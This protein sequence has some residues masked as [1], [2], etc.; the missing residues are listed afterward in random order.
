MNGFP[1]PAEVLSA[2]ITPAV[3]ISATGTLVLSTSNRL[4]RVIDRVRG[5]TAEAENLQNAAGQVR[6]GKREL[7]AD[8]IVRL[9]ERLLVLRSAMTAL[10]A[11]IGLLV[12]TS[13]AIGIVALFQWRYG[14]IP[15]VLGLAGACALLYG[16]LLLV[17]EARLAA[18]AILSELAYARQVIS[19]NGDSPIKVRHK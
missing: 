8:Q 15:V 19:S 11:A 10:Y 9:S 17:R 16:S 7:I 14:W 4:S 12:M 18:S 2:M 3:L 6:E 5:L 1:E 13:I